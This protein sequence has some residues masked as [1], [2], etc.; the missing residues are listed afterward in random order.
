MQAIEKAANEIKV[1]DILVINASSES[2]ELYS[3]LAISIAG[4]D[5]ETTLSI[6]SP[7]C[8]AAIDY[9]LYPFEF[10]HVLKS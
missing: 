6:K 10:D 4:I 3:V 7:D 2:P 8:A 1:G 5:G 9:V